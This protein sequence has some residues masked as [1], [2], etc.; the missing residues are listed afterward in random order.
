MESDR[1]LGENLI[2][3][4]L[5]CPLTRSIQLEIEKTLLNIGEVTFAK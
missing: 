1:D 3:E 4:T 2:P 5:A